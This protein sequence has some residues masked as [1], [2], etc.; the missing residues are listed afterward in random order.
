MLGWGG[1]CNYPLHDLVTLSAVLR[2]WEARW[3]ALV[4]ALTR[5]RMTLSVAAPPMYDEECEQVAAEHFAVCPDQ[6]DPQDGTV[7]TL[8]SYAA[9]IR[10]AGSWHFWWD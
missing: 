9:D 2:Q 10:G 4:V 5:S 7:T 1:I 6:Q 3:G 8:R